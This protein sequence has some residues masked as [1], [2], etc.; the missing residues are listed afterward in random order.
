MIKIDEQGLELAVLRGASQTL[1]A[2]PGIILLLDLPKQSEKRRAIGEYLAPF[3]F[4]YFPD[5]DEQAPTR[6]I[7]PAGLEVAAMRI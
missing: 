4:T 7:P 5:C 3:G 1:R 2:N 6:D